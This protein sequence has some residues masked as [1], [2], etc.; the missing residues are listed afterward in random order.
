M[1]R[2][3]YYFD[4]EMEVKVRKSSYEIDG[5]E[6]DGKVTIL[7]FINTIMTLDTVKMIT[8]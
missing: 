6:K 4:R 3:D 5:Q 8:V 7:R 2:R 1:Y